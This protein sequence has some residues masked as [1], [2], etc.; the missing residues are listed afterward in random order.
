MGTSGATSLS[1]T[2]VMTNPL[3][4][5][6]ATPAFGTGAANSGV[7]VAGNPIQGNIF[8]NPF[9]APFFYGSLMTGSG[10]TSTTSTTTSGSSTTST[11]TTTAR[12]GS[13]L[14]AMQMGMMMM[15][16]QNPNGVG[17]GVMSGRSSRTQGAGPRR[18]RPRRGRGPSRRRPAWRAVT[19][20]AEVPI[21]RSRK[22]SSIGKLGIFHKLLTPSR[23]TQFRF[24]RTSDCADSI[25]CQGGSAKNGRGPEDWE[26][27]RRGT[28]RVP[29]ELD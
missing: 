11:T 29:C 5:P 26:C 20:T 21:P 25:S 1:G 10:T 3:S 2:S 23:T 19:S 14:G 12:G 9:A 18:P 13:G 16:T 27:K 15:A 6:I 17:S 28:G 4:L 22:V 7:D 24:E 8:A